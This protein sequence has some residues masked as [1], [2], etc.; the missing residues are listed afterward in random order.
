VKPLLKQINFSNMTTPFF[1]ALSLLCL[2]PTTPKT[3]K[4]TAIE[5]SNNIKTNR[6]I[7][8]S[9]TN[10]EINGLELRTEAAVIL[11][12][13]KTQGSKQIHLNDLADG[14][15]F[16]LLKSNE[17]TLEIRKIEIENQNLL[18]I[19]IVSTEKEHYVPN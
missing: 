12:H 6:T 11:P 2:Q 5:I 15:Y 17:I 7:S 3:E 13:M 14:T 9:W 18:A 16:L 8:I 19:Q 10:E 4:Q 1:I